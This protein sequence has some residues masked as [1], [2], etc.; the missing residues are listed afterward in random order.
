MAEPP[1]QP[2]VEGVPAPMDVALARSDRVPLPTPAPV[3][4]AGP[5][6]RCRAARAARHR[7]ERLRGSRIRGA[8]R[9]GVHR[10]C[11]VWPVRAPPGSAVDVRPA[12]VASPVVAERTT[13]ASVGTAVR[14]V[15]HDERADRP[16]AQP[17]DPQT[18]V[19]VIEAS[20]PTAKKDLRELWRARETALMFA[21]RDVKVRYKQSLIG[22][23]WAILQPLL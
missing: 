3:E 1:A 2:R 15:Q 5:P 16:A 14:D 20:L 8:C 23:A 19:T 13:H 17:A 21:W 11:R 10:L 18:H 9:A 4:A 6:H 7:A 22:I 12:W